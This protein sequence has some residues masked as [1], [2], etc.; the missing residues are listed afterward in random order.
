MRAAARGAIVTVMLLSF[1]A[2]TTMQAIEDFTPSV[3]EQRIEVGDRVH[4]VARSGKAYDL[5]VT[6]VDEGSLEGHND[7]GKRY[8]IPFE[9]ILHVEVAETDVVA[10]AAGV[11]GTVYTVAAAVVMYAIIAW[12][13]EDD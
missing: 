8:K 12:A 2:C 6:R 7:S 11:L 4:V 5:T 13:S 10:S 9:A 1:S 3:L